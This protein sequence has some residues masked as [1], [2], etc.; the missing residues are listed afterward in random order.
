ME[1]TLNEKR[2][3]AVRAQLIYSLASQIIPTDEGP[4]YT[5]LIS[6][7]SSDAGLD[8]NTIHPGRDVYPGMTETMGLSIPGM[9]R[10]MLSINTQLSYQECARIS[11]L[12]DEKL[13]AVDWLQLYNG[14][15]YDMTFDPAYDRRV[16]RKLSQDKRIDYAMVATKY[17]PKVQGGYGSMENYMVI[18]RTRDGKIA[19]GIVSGDNT[20]GIM[21][22][23][24]GGYDGYCY[25]EREVG[26][27]EYHR[28][29]RE[30]NY[31]WLN[32]DL[33]VAAVEL[34]EQFN[35]NQE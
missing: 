29:I 5:S 23:I 10:D 22:H 34:I 12:I 4:I 9:F 35:Q 32:N 8:L 26:G 11:I 24:C 17:Y 18:T 20:T 30:G 16:T 6:M 14:K 33:T 31:P 7:L 13:Q 21:Y 25:A 1:L 19:K 27:R 15:T 28:A 3:L 2:Y